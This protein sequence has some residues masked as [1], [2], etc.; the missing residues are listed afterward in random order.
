MECDD[1]NLDIGSCPSSPPIGYTTTCSDFA[2]SRA[3]VECSQ[4]PPTDDGGLNGGAIAGI[5]IGSIVGLGFIVYFI[6]WCGE[7]DKKKKA[8]A[9]EASRRQ[10]EAVAA[11]QRGDREA[12]QRRDEA[13]TQRALAPA[14]QPPVSS[15]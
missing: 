5:V 4:G 12:Q 2:S 1:T 10:D 3:E 9:A 6:H 15:P 8:A 13:A 14:Q 7:A 11:Q